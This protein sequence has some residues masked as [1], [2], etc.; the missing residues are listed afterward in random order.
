MVEERYLRGRGTGLGHH[1]GDDDLAP[2]GI[3]D[4]R[5]SRKP[6]VR[7]LLQNLLHLGRRN[8]DPRALDHFGTAPHEHDCTVRPQQAEVTGREIAVRREHQPV[9]AG[10]EADKGAKL[11]AGFGVP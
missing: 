8:V 10:V 2:D 7:M 11:L 5:H 6:H 4:A 9:F 3:V 1:V